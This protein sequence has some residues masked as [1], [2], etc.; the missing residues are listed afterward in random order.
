MEEVVIYL[1][2]RLFAQ[3]TTL[4]V[5]GLWIGGRQP[6]FRNFS[7][8]ASVSS[9]GTGTVQCSWEELFRD[10]RD[11]KSIAGGSELAEEGQDVQVWRGDGKAAWRTSPICTASHDPQN[12]L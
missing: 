6:T 12:S 3:A 5:D 8:K 2:Q 4:L 9:R 1:S 11:G 10:C 7:L